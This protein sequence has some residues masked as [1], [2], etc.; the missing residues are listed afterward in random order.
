MKILKNFISDVKADKFKLISLTL[1]SALFIFNAVRLYAPTGVNQKT[2]RDVVETNQVKQEKVLELFY[3]PSCPHCGHAKEFLSNDFAIRYPDVKIKKY[4]I[5]KAGSEG[6]EARRRFKECKSK[7][8]IDRNAV[9][10]A[11][12]GDED[13]TIGFGG[14][15]SQMDYVEKTDKFI[16]SCDAN[17]EGGFQTAEVL[18]VDKSVDMDEVN[19]IKNIVSESTEAEKIL[20]EKK[21]ETKFG[22]VNF[23]KYSLTTLS[24]VFGFIDGFNPCA[25]W[26]LIFMISIIL[27]LKDKRKIWLIVGTFLITEAVLYYIFMAFWMNTL[28]MLEHVTIL[29]TFIGCVALYIAG[30]SLRD[31]W[32][33]DIACHVDNLQERAKIRGKIHDVVSR[34][35]TIMT[36][37]SMVALAAAVNMVEFACSS[38]LPVVYTK[39]LVDSGIS[40]FAKYAYMGLYNLFY[41]IDDFI[42]FGFAIFAVNKFI[43]E[44]YMKYTKLIAGVL[45]AIIGISMIF[46]PEF[47][48]SMSS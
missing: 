38:A 17:E 30:V 5:T 31:V 12:F 42:I 9:P 28:A 2:V 22:E 39:L 35:L 36:V 43:G 8:G 29:N 44:K 25:M 45:L 13:F 27:E 46:F 37:L 34:P 32:V 21:I 10:V 26:V 20:S 6:D 40:T 24:I 23:S 33:N 4:D 18:T 15:K 19:D 1:L 48:A 14:V 3:S 47:L 41:M 11:V 16:L 7:L